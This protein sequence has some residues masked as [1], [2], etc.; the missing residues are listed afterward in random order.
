MTESCCGPSEAGSGTC[1]PDAGPKIVKC[2][3][4]QQV[5]KRVDTLT[6]KALLAV[7]LTN[8]RLVE[9]RFCRTPTCQTVYYSVDGA[10]CFGEGDL[11]E[12]VYQKHSAEEEVFACYCFRYKVGDVRAAVA[13]GHTQPI[14]AAINAGVQAGQCACDIRNPQGSCCLGNIHAMIQASKAE[15]GGGSREAV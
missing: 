15:M 4:C 10:Q 2:P 6:L 12:R 13:Q 5:G 9:Y 8:I 7:P 11:R 14:V 3:T 1:E